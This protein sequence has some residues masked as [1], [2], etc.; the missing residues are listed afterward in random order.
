MIIFNIILFLYSN[1]E[2]DC[3]SYYI[4]GGDC[5][6]KIVKSLLEY[7]KLNFTPFV[8]GGAPGEFQS[9]VVR[10]WS[11]LHY[12]PNQSKKCEER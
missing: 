4:E 8:P 12:T 10:H 6:K 1:I 2:K 9:F 7:R 11:R 3:L 5:K